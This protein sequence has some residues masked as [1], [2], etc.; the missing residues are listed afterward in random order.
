MAKRSPILGYNHNVRHRGL[1][2]HVQTEDS[3]VG[4]P[5]IFTHLFHGGVIIS[6]RKLV[7]D[8]GSAEESIKSLMQAQH[9][10]VLKDLKSATFDEKIDAYLGGTP[11]LE[12][13]PAAGARQRRDTIV[14]PPPPTIDPPEMDDQVTPPAGSSLTEAVLARALPVESAADLPP[15]S[16]TQPMPPVISGRPPAGQPKRNR[17]DDVSAAFRAIAPNDDAPVMTD[18][19]P[20]VIEDDET[21]PTPRQHDIQRV[22]PSLAA[23]AGPNAKSDGVPEARSPRKTPSGAYAQYNVNRTDRIPIVHDQP[24]APVD[25]ERRGSGSPTPGASASQSGLPRPG[26]ASQSGIARPGSASQSGI[27]RPSGASA[28]QSGIPR[29]GSGSQSGIPRPAVGGPA[30]FPQRSQRPSQAGIAARAEGGSRPPPV[31]PPLAPVAGR[32]GTPSTPPPIARPAGRPHAPPAMPPPRVGAAS[33]PRT[34][35]VVS[36]PAVIVG[37]PP[38]VIGSGGG[39]QTTGQ[40]TTRRA[41]EEPARPNLFGKDLISEKSL[42]EVI[43]AYLSEDAAEE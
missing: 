43:L 19:V 21:T 25:R 36:R 7:Y 15:S 29:P 32:P 10:A 9:K 8:N 30:P 22:Y 26:S 14:T 18:A 11:G 3:G 31:A 37:G 2:F 6:T 13:S 39:G 40:P 12:P 16:A 34:G 5:H 42:D 23:A 35:V 33:P 24:T 41:R 38:K 27:A 20:A 17:E 28:S 4:N 1:I